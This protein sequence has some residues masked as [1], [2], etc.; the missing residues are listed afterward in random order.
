MQNKL[1]ILLFG[2]LFLCALAF[3][4]SR[5]LPVSAA[6]STS[7]NPSQTSIVSKSADVHVVT[8][9]QSQ[10]D[11]ERGFRQGYRDAVSDCRSAHHHRREYRHHHGEDD[12]ARGYADGYS[13][14]ERYDR[15]CRGA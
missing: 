5:D 3:F 12:Y 10:R 1:R 4:S 2:T 14:A 11:Y 6:A 9:V 15:A 13:R 8:I 7:A